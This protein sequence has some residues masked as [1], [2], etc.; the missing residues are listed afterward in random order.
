MGATL[1]FP[2]APGVTST[3]VVEGS[4]SS[5]VVNM[6]G[7]TI[8]MSTARVASLDLEGGVLNSSSALD[9]IIG[10]LTNNG[11]VDFTGAL[12]QLPVTG[13]Y[14]Q[15]SLGILD[16]RLDNG[17]PPATSPSDKLAIGGSATLNG[18][19]NLSAQNSLTDDQTWEV[20]TYAA[21]TGDFSTK[22]FPNDGNP[23]WTASALGNNVL[24]DN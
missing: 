10:N 11:T 12:H 7:A 6:N 18:T 9:N 20:M 17:T 16:I 19:L 14:T 2:A 3:F 21:H 8:A 23:F 1:A 13:N 5:A 22:N 4:P 24:V 15:G